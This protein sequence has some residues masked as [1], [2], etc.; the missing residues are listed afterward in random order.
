MLRFTIYL[1]LLAAVVAYAFRRGGRP[2]KQ[3]AIVLIA[4][5]A[6]NRAY[7]A[8]GSPGDYLSADYF[9]VFNDAW[10]LVALLG[11]ALTAD[12]FWPLCVA[13]LQIIATCAHYVRIADVEIL[14]IVYATM[15]RLPSW[16]QIVILLIGTWNY[17]RMR[18][19][20]AASTSLHQF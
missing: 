4:M 16:L 1:I 5:L 12:R 2:E 10:A 9:Y 15:I 11:V 7:H 3:V 14:P 18:A 13:A 8:L 6:F 17:A 20:R 19:S